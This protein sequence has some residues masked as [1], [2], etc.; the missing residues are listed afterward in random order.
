MQKYAIMKV[1]FDSALLQQ[2]VLT[3]GFILYLQHKLADV[4]TAEW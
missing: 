1:L 3:L 2:I 4:G